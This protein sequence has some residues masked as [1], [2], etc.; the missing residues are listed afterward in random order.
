MYWEEKMLNKI[1]G[2]VLFSLVGISFV[3]CLLT[4]TELEQSGNIVWTGILSCFIPR[5]LFW[6]VFFWDVSAVISSICWGLRP[7]LTDCLKI[8][9]T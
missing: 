2:Y 3:F 9:V 7:K 8:K 6:V 1:I 5:G 4:G